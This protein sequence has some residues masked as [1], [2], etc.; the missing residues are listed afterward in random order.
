M[1]GDLAHESQVTLI[2][3]L[4]FLLFALIVGGFVAIVF[5][6][7]KFRRD[8]E[9]RD[10]MLRWFNNLDIRQITMDTRL[11]ALERVVDSPEP[12]ESPLAPKDAP[13]AYERILTEDRLDP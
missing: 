7:V 2:G 9:N 12:H 4:C 3:L 10:A 8:R 1:R 6:R 11:T 5:L 13:T